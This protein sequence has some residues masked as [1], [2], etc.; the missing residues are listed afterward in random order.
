VPTRQPPG[1]T[2]LSGRWPGLGRL[3][4]VGEVVEERAREAAEVPCIVAV[5]ELER[6][7]PSAR[8]PGRGDDSDD[9]P[10]CLEVGVTS[11]L[12]DGDVIAP[13][14]ERRPAGMGV[15]IADEGDV[16]LCGGPDPVE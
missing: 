7:R 4:R 5:E 14:W 9:R 6:G 15:P 12:C 13:A 8:K 1:V 16:A 10:R 3:G 2:R 11:D